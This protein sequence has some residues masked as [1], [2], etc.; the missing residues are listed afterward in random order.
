MTWHDI[1]KMYLLLCTILCA[2]GGQFGSAHAAEYRRCGT[3]NVEAQAL[4]TWQRL[5][6]DK[7]WLMATRFAGAKQIHVQILEAHRG[8][9]AGR[10]E[11]APE[12]DDRVRPM[13]HMIHI[14]HNDMA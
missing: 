3:G 7:T 10:D 6:M 2:K 11:T 4:Y 5:M 9:P 1:T 8:V 13:L 12:P 14:S